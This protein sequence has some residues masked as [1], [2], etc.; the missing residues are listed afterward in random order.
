MNLF[1]LS[2]DIWTYT[3]SGFLEWKDVTTPD[4]TL[5]NRLVRQSYLN[6]IPRSKP[7]NVSG[8]LNTSNVSPK[9]LEWVSSRAITPKSVIIRVDDKIENCESLALIQQLIQNLSNVYAC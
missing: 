1:D 7:V 8:A 3:I 5:V 6:L 9:I 2:S 4:I